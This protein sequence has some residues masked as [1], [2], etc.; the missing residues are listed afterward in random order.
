MTAPA[1]AA[2][3]LAASTATAD[4]SSGQPATVTLTAAG[5]PV[6]WSAWCDPGID[7]TLSAAEGTASPGA[8]S[9]LVLSVPASEGGDAGAVCHIWPGGLV[10]SV[11][12]PGPQPSPAPSPSD[13]AATDTPAPSPSPS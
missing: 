13:T 1:T 10:I 3:M 9:L 4:L 5:A 6:N 8:P 2:G 12:L 7:V 11:V